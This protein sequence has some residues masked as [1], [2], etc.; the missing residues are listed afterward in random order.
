MHRLITVAESKDIVF[1]VD[2]NGLNN[3]KRNLQARQIRP[4]TTRSDT[5]ALRGVTQITNDTYLA[6]IEFTGTNYELG[7]YASPEA[8][9]RA[10]DKAAR[11]IYGSDARTN[12]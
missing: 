8:A 6:E 4:W 9:G 10:Y 1:H 3:R 11:D 12:F 7:E 5:S 2:G